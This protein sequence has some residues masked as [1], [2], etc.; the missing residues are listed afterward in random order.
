MPIGWISDFKLTGVCRR[1]TWAC[2]LKWKITCAPTKV[3]KVLMAFRALFLR[4]QTFY[5]PQHS[6][7]PCQPSVKKSGCRTSQFAIPPCFEV[8]GDSGRI[9]S[10]ANG[11]GLTS[12]NLRRHVGPATWEQHLPRSQ[13]EGSC[14][15]R[16]LCR[17]R[18][19]RF[20]STAVLHGQGAVTLRCIV[21]TIL[22]FQ[23]GTDFLYTLFNA[24]KVC[25]FL[26]RTTCLHTYLSP[27]LPTFHKSI[28]STLPIVPHFPRFSWFFPRR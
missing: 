26:S 18:V 9:T 17:S 16:G 24:L 6:R 25:N 13:P 2:G 3:R 21:L 14:D 10:E 8:C 19:E 23:T 20:V 7:W 5:S 12:H 1:T 4:F 27:S 22:Q 28:Y 15:T 11:S